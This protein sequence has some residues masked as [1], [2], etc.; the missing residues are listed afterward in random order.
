MPID[1]DKNLS[2]IELFWNTCVSRLS[3]QLTLP[4]TNSR[5]GIIHIRKRV[6]LLFQKIMLSRSFLSFMGRLPDST[7]ILWQY[8]AG[9]T[10]ILFNMIRYPALLLSLLAGNPHVTKDRPSGGISVWWASLPR[11]P[12]QVVGSEWKYR[13]QVCP[14]QTGELSR[15]PETSPYG[16][17]V[18]PIV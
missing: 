12:S 5:A 11:R 7:G 1:T 18:P 14:R 9:V 2:S 13:Q 16:Q 15:W 17:E 10:S 4:D 6:Q 8:L 3:Q